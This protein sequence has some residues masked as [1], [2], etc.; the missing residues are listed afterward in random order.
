MN[1]KRTSHYP[2]GYQSKIEYY[3]YK[4]SSAVEKLSI[5]DIKFFTGK[6][7]YFMAREEARLARLAE[8]PHSLQY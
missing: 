8:T 5:K 7:E 3:Q 6:L 2:N 1:N 4:V